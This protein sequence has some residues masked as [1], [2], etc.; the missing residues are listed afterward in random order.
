MRV[1]TDN[2]MFKVYLTRKSLNDMLYFCLLSAFLIYHS[3]GK[4]DKK[5]TLSDTPKKQSWCRSLFHVV[6]PI[7]FITFMNMFQKNF[8]STIAVSIFI[9]NF[10]FNVSKIFARNVSLKIFRKTFCRAF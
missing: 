5:G 6:P 9:L 8:S 1:A 2:I 10:L 3:W 4:N 7:L